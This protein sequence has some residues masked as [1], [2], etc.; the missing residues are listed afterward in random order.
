MQ[1]PS[2]RSPKPPGQ[3]AEYQRRQQQINPMSQ[4][5][6]S[7]DPRGGGEQKRGHAYLQVVHDKGGGLGKGIADFLLAGMHSPHH[8]P[9][10]LQ[11]IPLLSKMCPMCD[12]SDSCPNCSFRSPCMLPEMYTCAPPTPSPLQVVPCT[13]HAVQPGPLPQHYPM[14]QTC[15]AETPMHS[16]SIPDGVQSTCSLGGLHVL[17]MY[18]CTHTFPASDM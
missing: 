6:S 8:S 18:A 10:C 16:T 3:T 7:G 15:T 17:C 4:V 12:G 13:V 9:H 11:P 14:H 2:I 5:S 1:P